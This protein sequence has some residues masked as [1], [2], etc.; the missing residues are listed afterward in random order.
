M[1]TYRKHIIIFAIVLVALT[2]LLSG[3]AQAQTS[4]GNSDAY[5]QLQQ[6]IHDLES[7][8]ADLKAQ[9]NTLSAQIGVMDNQMKLTE[10]RINANQQQITDISL[11]IDSTT[12]RM[13][14]LEGS[15]DN[16]SKVLINRIVATYKTS[17]INPVQ[18]VLSSKSI[19]DA[20][21]R[22]NYLKMVQGHDKKLLLDTQQAKN[23]YEN[24][25]NIFE[26]KK[27][28]I[29]SLKTQLEDY[30]KQLDQQKADKQKLLSV[31]E[32]DEAKYKSILEQTKAQ[33]ASFSNFTVSQGGASLLGSQTACDDWGCYYNQRDSQ[34]GGMALNGTEY[35]IASDGCLMTS[36]AMVYTHY[37]HKDI[38]PVSINSNSSNFA[39][40]PAALLK[41]SIVANGVSS[42]R[43]SASIDSTLAG[44][45]PVIVGISYDSGPYPDHFLV[46]VSGSNGDYVM[47]DPYTPNGHKIPFTSKY[48]VG[49]IRE[50]DKV[51]I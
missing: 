12:K 23:D 2:S 9:G 41:R 49:S 10:Y 35:S 36:M 25:K 22:V 43:V 32:G 6:K 33:L 27:K 37:G 34:W 5:N 28:K 18:F 17:T 14:N 30:T 44:G 20:I 48:S 4:G 11:D 13:N 51:S 1:I 40:I 45:D 19:G 7:K 46:L 47:N 15:L 42:N 16:V 38:T 50:I 3:P 31:T 29:E 8:V 39:G 26:D 21:E 24:Q